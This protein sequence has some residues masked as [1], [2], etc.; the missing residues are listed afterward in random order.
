[1]GHGEVRLVPGQLAL[2]KIEVNGRLIEIPRKRNDLDFDKPQSCVEA[3]THLIRRVDRGPG[4]I[5]GRERNHQIELGG[6]FRLLDD[7]KPELYLLFHGNHPVA[8]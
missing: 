6:V 1:M 8:G 3:L 5:R 7:F 4:Q 2:Q